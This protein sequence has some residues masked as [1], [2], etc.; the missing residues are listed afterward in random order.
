[1]QKLSLHSHYNYGLF[2]C[3]NYLRGSVALAE[4]GPEQTSAAQA[5]S[6]TSKSTAP[7]DALAPEFVAPAKLPASQLAALVNLPAPRPEAPTGPLL[8]P[9]PAPTPI[10]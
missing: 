3:H 10:L 1:M 9:E 7:I 6:P 5:N 8:T 2:F 4:S